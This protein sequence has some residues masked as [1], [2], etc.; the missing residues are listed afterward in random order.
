MTKIKL[1]Q[2]FTLNSCCHNNFKTIISNSDIYNKE[3]FV[4]HHFHYLSSRPKTQQYPLSYYMNLTGIK[5][6][7]F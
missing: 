4:L 2:L 3:I 1:K 5:C 7:I 6:C